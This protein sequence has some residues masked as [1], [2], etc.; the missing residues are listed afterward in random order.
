MP[1]N[2]NKKK[3]QSQKRP[4]P[5]DP[6]TNHRVF[7]TDNKR[8]R[9]ESAPQARVYS[10]KIRPVKFGLAAIST[11]K[12][13]PVQG[14]NIKRIG[15]EPEEAVNV[16]DVEYKSVT[17]TI[18]RDDRD[19]QIHTVRPFRVAVGQIPNM[20]TRYIWDNC[21]KNDT[22]Y[23]N[24]TKTTTSDFHRTFNTIRPGDRLGLRKIEPKKK[25]TEGQ[26]VLPY[27]VTSMTRR[28]H[29]KDESQIHK[30]VPYT[31]MP[32]RTN[33]SDVLCSPDGEL[34]E[35]RYKNGAIH[36]PGSHVYFVEENE[37]LV[38]QIGLG[39]FQQS[40]ATT[41]DTRSYADED[42]MDDTDH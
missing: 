27:A 32:S 20:E 18:H 40:G 16:V 33:G 11:A 5:N 14:A 26:T 6:T 24:G 13:L 2:D 31:V 3:Q 42:S 36:P 17:V 35:V 4:S 34:F 15:L 28:Q 8:P 41:I 30:G 39:P 37:E 23:R 1:G 7:F 21:K 10:R 25:A 9:A 19:T 29:M 22:V 38:C 12:S